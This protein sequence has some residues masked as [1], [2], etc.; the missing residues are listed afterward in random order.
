MAPKK[1]SSTAK[2]N[3]TP[4]KKSGQVAAAAPSSASSTARPAATTPSPTPNTPSF[5][6]YLAAFF[7]AIAS[8]A[9]FLHYK[10]PAPITPT[11]SAASEAAGQGALF[12][13]SNVHSLIE[14]LSVDIGYRIVGTREHVRAEEWLLDELRKYEGT[15]YLGAEAGNVQ[16]EIWQQIGD[17]AHR[18]DFISST[19]WK[20][21]YSMSNVVV[22]IS[23]GTDE[24]KENS[25]LVNAHLDSTLPSPGAA[26]DGVGVGIMMELLRILTTPGANRKRLRHSAVLLFNNGEGK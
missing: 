13:E 25:V 12:S 9:L 24:S 14:K 2:S 4:S 26:D 15:H 8:A 7:L 20:K 6:V 18:F 1:A 16:V 11:Q 22:R 23:D 10:L 5:L 3:G 21:Y 17:G 19:V